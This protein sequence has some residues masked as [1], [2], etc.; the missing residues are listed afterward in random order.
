M[1]RQTSSGNDLFDEFGNQ[2][3]G[4]CFGNSRR[5]GTTIDTCCALNVKCNIV[6]VDIGTLS[7]VE[8]DKTIKIIDSI[9]LDIRLH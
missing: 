9:P 6:P 2:C 5:S 4:E 8:I 1:Q 3:M 7:K